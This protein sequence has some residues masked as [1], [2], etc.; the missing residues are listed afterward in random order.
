MSDTAGSRNSAA[1]SEVPGMK[2]T[3]HIVSVLI[4]IAVLCV[5]PGCGTTKK[6]GTAAGTQ[7][8][9]VRITRFQIPSPVTARVPY[10]A[11]MTA[12]GLE[13]ATVLRGYFFWNGEGPFEY[14]VTNVDERSGRVQFFLYTGNPRTYVIT[15]Y[16][17]YRNRRTGATGFSNTASAGAVQVR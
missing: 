5:Q 13:N 4:I 10:P 9:D 6:S 12:T 11:T 17:L 16:V 14:P 1:I 8:P 15:G 2:K 3:V 7:N